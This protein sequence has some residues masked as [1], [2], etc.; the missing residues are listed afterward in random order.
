MAGHPSGDGVDGEA[1]LD[2]FLCEFITELPHLVLGLGDGESVAGGDDDAAGHAEQH[3][4]F[5][6][7]V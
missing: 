7:W 2:A 1:D 4:G 6:A 5:I 3:R